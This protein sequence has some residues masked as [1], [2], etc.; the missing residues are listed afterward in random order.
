MVINK[1]YVSFLDILHLYIHVNLQLCRGKMLFLQDNFKMKQ[2]NQAFDLVFVQASTIRHIHC[3]R[4]EGEGTEFE[5]HL[6]E[7][8]RVG[9]P[10]EGS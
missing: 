7:D 3:T 10:L 5:V 1:S 8:L 6:F 9:R 2:S 4:G